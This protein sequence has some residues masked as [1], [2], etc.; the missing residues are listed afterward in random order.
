MDCSGGRAITE[1]IMRA[2]GLSYEEAQ[3]AKEGNV[4]VNPTD[5]PE[6]AEG[7][8]SSHK[9]LFFMPKWCDFGA[10]KSP[11][12][13]FQGVFRRRVFYTPRCCVTV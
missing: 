7:V 4:R 2:T 1:E 8:L 5:R 10:Q 11:D 12:V 13:L 6:A 9:A 3:K